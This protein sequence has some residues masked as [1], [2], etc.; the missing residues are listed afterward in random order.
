MS[1]L[2]KRNLTPDESKDDKSF[3]DSK[4][5]NNFKKN[6]KWNKNKRGKNKDEKCNDITWHTKNPQMVKDAFSVPFSVYQGFNPKFSNSYVSTI[7]EL[8][9]EVTGS[10]CSMYFDWYTGINNNTKTDMSDQLNL[11]ASNLWT[12]MRS[13]NSGATNYQYM[14][15][16][17]NTVAASIDIVSTISYLSR[18]FG[19][20]KYYDNRN[21]TVPRSL[22]AASGVNY[23]DFLANIATYRGQFNNL[24]AYASSI[25]LPKQFTLIDQVKEMTE[26]YYKDE[27]TDTG[28]EQLYIIHKPFFHIYDSTYNEKGGAVRL[29]E[30]SDLGYG[31]LS[32][33]RDEPIFLGTIGA[34]WQTILTTTESYKF[35]VLLDILKAQ[36]DALVLD[37]D[38][39]IMWGDLIKA[40]G[41]EAKFYQFAPITEDYVESPSYSSEFLLMIHNATILPMPV[42]TSKT[43]TE[44]FTWYYAP[45]C[46]NFISQDPSYL[47]LNTG[48]QLCVKASY[49]SVLGGYALNKILDT[50]SDNPSPEDV[51]LMTRWASNWKAETGTL[52]Y[53]MYPIACG[54]IFLFGAGVQFNTKESGVTPLITVRHYSTVYQPAGELESW[55]HESFNGFPMLMKIGVESSGAINSVE[56][57]GQKNNITTITPDTLMSMHRVD[58]SSLLDIPFSGKF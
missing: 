32:V 49:K 43:L 10:V 7:T 50:E 18:F 9:T 23:S 25:V 41:G 46:Q 16:F 27:D 15:L 20:C 28:R 11:A 44:D 2:N 36:I 34:D 38:T 4:K 33:N 57:S 24:I 54:T 26:H 48:L 12:F 35:S 42:L 1:N 58:L 29:M 51:V 3:N 40:Y 31:S 19:I 5:G 22:F 8:T 21:R 55:A 39:N 47:T 37:E 56:V 30:W 17:I 13:R 6:K 52:G 14:D 45:S 53:L